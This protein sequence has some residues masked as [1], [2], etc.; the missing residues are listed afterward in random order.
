M[1]QIQVH[2]VIFLAPSLHLFAISLY[3][4][5]LLQHLFS[6]HSFHSFSVSH[7]PFSF[8][9]FLLSRVL[10]YIFSFFF[11]FFIAS[12]ME[13]FRKKLSPKSVEEKIIYVPNVFS[14]PTSSELNLHSADVSDQK[15]K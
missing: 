12:G 11:F 3:I 9:L 15:S 6:H 8:I 7:L 13:Q 4:V 14:H 5:I 2:E 1:L 10:L